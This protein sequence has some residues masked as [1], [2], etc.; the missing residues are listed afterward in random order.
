MLFNILLFGE[1]S[2]GLYNVIAFE[3][4]RIQSEKKM[5]VNCSMQ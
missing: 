3:G 1:C 5:H 2:K 4:R